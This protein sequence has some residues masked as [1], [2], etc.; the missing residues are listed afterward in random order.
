MINVI[1]EMPFRLIP[2]NSF[3]LLTSI[4][5]VLQGATDFIDRISSA[6]VALRF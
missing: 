1:K 4:P 5:R 2:L 3:T 6:R